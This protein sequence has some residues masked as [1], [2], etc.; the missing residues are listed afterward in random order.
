M[1]LLAMYYL[2]CPIW[3]NALGARGFERN[4]QKDVLSPSSAFTQTTF[5]MRR[6]CRSCM[7]SAHLMRPAALGLMLWA[8]PAVTTKSDA[9]RG[10]SASPQLSCWPHS[11]MEKEGRDQIWEQRA[12]EKGGHG[13]APSKIRRWLSLPC[14]HSFVLAPARCLAGFSWSGVPV[15]NA[16]AVTVLDLRGHARASCLWG[17]SLPSPQ[18]NHVPLFSL[19]FPSWCFHRDQL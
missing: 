11:L 7:L 10:L 3:E 6:V 12:Y 9:F 17:T 5:A 13:Q 16:G 2:V 8:G 4:F 14:L 19:L 15:P 1:A 18:E